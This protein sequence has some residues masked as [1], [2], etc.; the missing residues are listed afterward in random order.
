M[1]V[2][3]ITLGTVAR[4][5]TKAA[6]ADTGSW[7]SQFVRHST[8]HMEVANFWACGSVVAA[9]QPLLL[10]VSL[11][12]DERSC[13][14]HRIL[15]RTKSGIRSFAACSVRRAGPYCRHHSYSGRS[16]PANQPAPSHAGSTSWGSEKGSRPAS[17]QRCYCAI[18]Q[19]ISSIGRF[20]CVRCR[21][22]II[23]FHQRSKEVPKGHLRFVKA[24]G[25]R[26]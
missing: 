14:C 24:R 15:N 9:R 5:V 7:L 22:S 19:S 17:D 23:A 1:D 6:L 8:C 18:G 21:A 12:S 13:E 2:R 26:A 10:A 25:E 11:S 16:A 4:A 3:C 20:S